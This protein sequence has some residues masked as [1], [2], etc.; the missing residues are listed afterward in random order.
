MK[1]VVAVT[2]TLAM[3]GASAP[4]QLKMNGWDYYN[5]PSQPS[6]GSSSGGTLLLT[7]TM[8]H[9]YKASVMRGGSL[10]A[11]N[12]YWLGQGLTVPE[13][14]IQ[15]SGTNVIIAWPDPSTRYR[16]FKSDVI[17]P[18]AWLP[19]N[20]LPAIVGNE[21]QVTL[22]RSGNKSFFQLYKPR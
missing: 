5:Y 1:T 8:D 18:L 15:K 22:P 16:L 3:L 20:A 19:T 17:P 12:G 6:G 21:K 2:F 4:A 11:W 13:L 10:T 9:P 7:G 14:R